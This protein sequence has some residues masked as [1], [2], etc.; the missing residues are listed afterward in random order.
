MDSAGAGFRNM[1]DLLHFF[2]E[3]FTPLVTHNRNCDDSWW[4]HEI[5][6]HLQDLFR[7]LQAPCRFSEI[8]SS[9]TT[10]PL[11]GVA[12]CWLPVTTWHRRRFDCDVFLVAGCREI[13][14][15]PRCGWTCGFPWIFTCRWLFLYTP[16]IFSLRYPART[17][18]LKLY[19]FILAHH[20][21]YPFVNFRGVYSSR[22]DFSKKFNLY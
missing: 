8:Q 14:G 5:F 10:K 13:S 1:E 2:D 20:F 4:H 11:S 9:E 15:W 21:G 12:A 19:I 17:Q 3:Q 22:W 7:N 18:D 6:R 16:Q